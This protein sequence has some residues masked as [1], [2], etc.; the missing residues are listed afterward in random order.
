MAGALG[1]RIEGID[2]AGELDEETFAALRRLFLE[3]LLLVF[4]RQG[5][6]TPD[7]QVSFAGRWGELQ[8]SSARSAGGRPELVE[9][10]T[11]GGTEPRPHPDMPERQKL[12]RADIWHS[13]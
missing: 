5:H 10:A 6:L 11:G 13:D 9:L 8:R 4:P 12:A 3:H 2:L 1:A 7:Q